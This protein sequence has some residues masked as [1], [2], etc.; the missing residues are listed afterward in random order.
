MGNTP[1]RLCG[2]LAAMLLTFSAIAQ[3]DQTLEIS[4]DF[5]DN[6]ISEVLTSLSDQYPLTFYYDM[7]ILPKEPTGLSFDGASLTE[8]MDKLLGQSLLGYISYR[9][10]IVVIAPKYVMEQDFGA[11][12]Y[13][14]LESSINEPAGT[15]G[16]TTLVIGD[17]SQLGASGQT[18]LVG[19]LFDEETNEPIIGANVTIPNLDIGA[20][21]EIDGTFE[22][23][24]PVGEHI[25]VI[26]YIGFETYIRELKIFSDGNVDIILERSAVQL[27]EVTVKADAPDASIE[28][29]QI[30]V[31]TLDVK[32]IK[33]LPTFFGEADVVQSLLLYPGVST[34]G[35]GATGF[36]VRGG[37]V[38][39]NLIMQDNGMFMNSSHALGFY[40]AFNADLIGRVDLYKGNMPA[41][42]GGR[43]AAVMDIEMR[44]GNYGDWSLKGGI[45]PVSSRLSFEGPI[46]KDK[47]SII[48]GGRVS[49]ADWLLK[50]MKP[51]EVQNSHVFFYDVN[52][53]LSTRIN[54]KNTLIVSG[55][56]SADEFDFNREFGFAY[57]TFLAQ[58]IYKTILNDKWY[59]N[60]S[61]TGSQYNSTQFDYQGTNASSLD[62]DIQYLKVRDKVTYQANKDLRVDA[63]IESIW[64]KVNPG[65]QEP[66]DEN[67]VV[68]PATLEQEQANEAAVYIQ[69]EYDISTR[70]HINGGLRFVNYRFTGP[71]T[72]FEYEDPESPDDTEIVD[73]TMHGSG[74]IV[75]YNSIEPRLS[76][77]YKLSTST[78]IKAGYSRTAQFINQIFNSDSPTPTSQ[79]QLST[80]YIQPQR[81]H[82]LSAGLFKNFKDNLWETSFEVYGRYIDALF[83]YKDFA[84]LVMNPHLETELL[85][86]IGRTYGAE[87]S[88]KKKEGELNGWM[89]YTLS[90]S[91]R[92]VEG[93]NNGNWY[94]SNF[95][96]K[97]VFSFVLN[98][99]PNRRNTLTFNFNYSTGRPTS[100]PV[101]T[102]A[103]VEGLVVPAYT[104]R[105]ALR[106]PAY[107]RLDIAY[108][109]GKGYKKDKKIQTSWTFSIYNVYG[110]RNAFSVFYT[111]AAFKQV[112]ANQLSI[113]GSALPAFTLNFE[114][115]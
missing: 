81:S 5:A 55:Y 22:L 62:S 104:L 76:L 21:S 82:N 107:H 63:G 52:A 111:Q 114:F 58:A 60:F 75:S 56:A 20:V 95:D 31:A 102:Y 88:I 96:K 32:S 47:M 91:E 33:K 113:L 8:V 92:Q 103:T 39:Q 4:G 10:Y 28:G 71:K 110:R 49:H 100:P 85:P 50:Q 72:V 23:T 83:D 34:I 61:I 94:L 97:H 42:Y 86:G 14:A 74:T 53:R 36:N 87:F 38:D 11:D 64:Y 3:S 30:G 29:G 69:A 44:D 35:E 109:V 84:E 19:T 80:Q 1:E 27:E 46:I 7:S 9:D 77:R 48:A 66:L 54:E 45:G 99:Q 93:I 79:W 37:D 73:S 2:F 67:S 26:R 89:S 101:G 6:T 108:T 25:L 41:E 18:T 105:N 43:L 40:S 59:N 24:M 13:Q 68:I 17:I 106:I 112:Q 78:S 98:Y 90:R 16:E 51:P 65:T 15:S 12:Y 57:E 115:L 70:F